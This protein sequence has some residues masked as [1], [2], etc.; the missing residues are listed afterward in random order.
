[1]KAVSGLLPSTQ[2]DPKYK[3]NYIVVVENVFYTK[4]VYKGKRQAIELYH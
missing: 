2:R 3:E 4:L 1:V